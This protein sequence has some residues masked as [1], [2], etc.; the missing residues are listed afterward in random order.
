[1]QQ[2]MNSAEL[3]ELGLLLD[4]ALKEAA[5]SCLLPNEATKLKARVPSS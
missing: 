2:L 4:A 3:A 1:M 5:Q